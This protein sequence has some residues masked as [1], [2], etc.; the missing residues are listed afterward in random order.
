MNIFLPYPNSII[1]SVK[2]L[3]DK[4]LIKQILECKQI[5]DVAIGKSSAYSNHPIVKHYVK[6]REFIIHYG[7]HA[8]QEYE[9]RFG[10]RHKYYEVFKK[11]FHL[12]TIKYEPFYAEKSINDINCIRTTEN[13]GEL[14]MKKLINKWNNDKIKPKWTKENIPEFYNNDVK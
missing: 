12:N 9:Y 10:K 1:D 8:C 2:S 6:Y 3:D 7:Y 14:Y 4:R 11:K 5:Y 13:V